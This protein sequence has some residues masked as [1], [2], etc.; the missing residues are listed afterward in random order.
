LSGL[1][2]WGLASLFYDKNWRRAIG[3]Y[4]IAVLIHG[5]WNLFALLSGI[6]PVLPD[7]QSVGNFPFFLSQV[8]PFVLFVLSLINLIILIRINHKLR[9]QIQNA[10]I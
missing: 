9:R 8:G 3:N 1:V 6:I 10:A 7:P 2:G 4:L 5:T